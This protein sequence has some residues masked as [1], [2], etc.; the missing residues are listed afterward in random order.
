[1]E[2]EGLLRGKADTKV[3]SLGARTSVRA[4]AMTMPSVIAISGD[5]EPMPQPPEK[6]HPALPP[7]PDESTGNGKSAAPETQLPPESTTTPSAKRL[8]RFKLPGGIPV[9]SPGVSRKAGMVPAEYST[10]EFETRVASYS[11]DEYDRGSLGPHQAG[12]GDKRTRKESNDDSWMEIL[13][14]TQDRRI[15]TQE[16]SFKRNGKGGKH[17]RSDPE[18]ASLEVAKALAAVLDRKP[19]SD[20]ETDANHDADTVDEVQ[21]I[22]RR[23]DTYDR[24]YFSQLPN[25]DQGYEQ[26]FEPQESEQEHEEVREEEKEEEPTTPSG[27][28]Y[29]HHQRAQRRLGYFDL[30][31]ER[32]HPSAPGFDAPVPLQQSNDDN[33]EDD[34]GGFNALVDSYVAPLIPRKIVNPTPTRDRIQPSYSSVTDALELDPPKHPDYDRETGH[35]FVGTSSRSNGKQPVNIDSGSSKPIL[36]SKTAALIELYRERERG[37]TLPKP[38]VTPPS[39]TP[40]SRLPVRALP[41]PP[42]ELVSPPKTP[43]M[44]TLSPVPAPPPSEIEIIEHPLVSPDENGSASPARYKHGAPLHNVVE[45]EEE[46]P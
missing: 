6:P 7:I 34:D 15:N 32:R 26:E 30:H 41:T 12:D 31:P 9:P 22:P 24:D 25:Q 16:A 36:P 14:A 4:S 13:V 10:V 45:E 3:I 44:P 39:V 33:D 17:D 35:P 27:L 8:S 20:D 37:T 21:L 23:M 46:E 42:K 19:L 1:M 40:P 5:R 11:D 2:F 43:P 18:S 28:S 29:L 38:S